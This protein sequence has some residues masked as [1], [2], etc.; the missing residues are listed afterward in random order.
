MSLGITQPGESSS[1]DLP[2]CI[3]PDDRKKSCHHNTNLKYAKL[4]LCE[5]TARIMRLETRQKI[6]AHLETLSQ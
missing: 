4:S 6:C 2:G 5:G 1:N 3:A